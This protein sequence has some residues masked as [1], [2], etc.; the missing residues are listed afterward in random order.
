MILEK[1]YTYQYDNEIILVHNGKNVSLLELKNLIYNQFLNFKRNRTKNLIL[2]GDSSFEF[3]INFFA[4][5]FAN[6]NL[7][8]ISDKNRIKSLTFEYILPNKIEKQDIR[9]NI[10]FNQLDKENTQIN[11]Y[12]SGSSGEPKTITKNYQNVENE[13]IAFV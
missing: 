13:A 5:L 3:I 10:C 12:T 6:K 11:F 8:L 4:G 9:E 2:L 7:Y 1:F